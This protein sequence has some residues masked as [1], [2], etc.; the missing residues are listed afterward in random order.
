MPWPEPALSRVRAGSCMA[1]DRQM[2]FIAVVRFSSNLSYCDKRAAVTLMR[3]KGVNELEKNLCNYSSPRSGSSFC[4]WMSEAG[5]SEACSTVGNND[6][7]R[8]TSV[9][10]DNDH[11]HA[12]NK[13]GSGTIITKGPPACPG[14]FFLLLRTQPCV[15]AVLASF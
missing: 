3:R 2:V 8:C 11:D 5:S 14:G 4:F 1:H 13:V 6:H 10:H 7:D 9:D 12:R 15:N